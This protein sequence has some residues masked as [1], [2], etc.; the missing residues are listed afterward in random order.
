MRTLEAVKRAGISP[1]SGFIARMGESDEQLVSLAFAIRD[2]DTDSIPVNFLHPVDGTPLAGR[3]E[4]DP[5]RCLRIL[6]L[7]R[8]ACPSK[9]IRIAGG[10]ER[11]L[12]SLQ[13]LA[14]YPANAIFVGDYLTTPG[15][16]AEDD[17]QMLADLGFEIE[18][19]AL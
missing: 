1:S 10:R 4:L 18:E 5:R 17:W 19:C 2:L 3:E 7:L 13:P 8:L 12:R 14:L 16:R 6:A 15:Q 9:E 11:N